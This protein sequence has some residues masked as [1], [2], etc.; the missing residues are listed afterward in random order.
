[1]EEIRAAANSAAMKAPDERD[2]F[3]K[4]S[5]K[6]ANIVEIELI[7]RLAEQYDEAANREQEYIRMHGQAIGGFNGIH[8]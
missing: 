3:I 6:T 7:K 8:H 5:Y 2:S 4:Q 1:M